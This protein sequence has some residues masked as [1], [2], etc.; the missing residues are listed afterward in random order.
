MW[1]LVA[2]EGEWIGAELPLEPGWR[3]RFVEVL[4]APETTWFVAEADGVVIGGVYVQAMQGIAHLGMA[5]VD[6][7]RGAGLGRALLDAAIAWAREQNCHKVG[8]EVW[9]H[10][11]R[12]RRLYQRAGF[13]DEGVLRRHYRRRNGELWDA[14][15]MGLVL[16][17]DSPGR[18]AS[19]ADHALKQG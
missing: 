12:A 13:V 5:I 19:T 2:A 15:V 16:D 9:P 7:H 18:P 11:L 17:V 8:L 1:T 4:D 10:N 3:D 14:V 6:G